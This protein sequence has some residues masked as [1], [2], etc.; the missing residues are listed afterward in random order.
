MQDQNKLFEVARR[1]VEDEGCSN[2]DLHFIMLCVLKMK[3]GCTLFY[4]SA[5]SFDFT[6]SSPPVRP[7]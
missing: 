1:L 2:E 3:G 5:T 4:A 6:G 7:K